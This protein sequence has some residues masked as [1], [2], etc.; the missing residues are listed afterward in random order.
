[1]C[2]AAFIA[3][4]GSAASAVNIETVTVGN[5]GN[6][7]DPL[8]GFGTV[9]YEF[10]MGKFEITAGQYT[11]FLNAVAK[12][13]TYELYSTFMW[14][15]TY[16][17]CHI[18][19]GGS[20]GGYTYSVATD[21]AKRPVT[22]VSWTSAARFANW[23]TNG[24][25]TG[26]QDLTTT[27]ASSYY[28]NGAVS[29]AELRAVTRIADEDRIAGKKYYFIPT[30]DEWY[31]AAYHK[32]DGVTGNYWLYPTGGN[33]EPSNDLIDPD[34]GYNA[35]FYQSGYTIGSPYWRTEVGEFEN[36]A[37]RY[38][39]FDQVGN[40]WEWN[41]A[42]IAESGR[43]K[44]GGSFNHSGGLQAAV[45][46]NMYPGFGQNDLGFR[47]SEVPEPAALSLLVLGAGAALLRRRK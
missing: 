38:G 27:E 14:V 34:P 39:T 28:L 10:R 12:T 36:S 24:Q 18:Y 41:E 7:G 29:E 37:S 17:G 26:G 30:E 19:R 42:I 43:G 44:R 5:V 46:F 13:D 11:E 21:Y 16:G 47:V 15:G 22:N 32:N 31:K 4:L 9:D 33:S 25:P 1:M 45:R 20:S 35:N 23:L 40:V 3:A 6:A 8:T 2:V